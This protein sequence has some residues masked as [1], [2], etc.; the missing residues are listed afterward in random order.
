MVALDALFVLKIIKKDKEMDNENILSKNA[1]E[2]D[3]L[4]LSYN[5]FLDLYAEINSLDFMELSPEL[6]LHKIKVFLACIQS[7]YPTGQYKPL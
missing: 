6:R 7:Y 1:K 3:F 4:N 5:R 2:Y